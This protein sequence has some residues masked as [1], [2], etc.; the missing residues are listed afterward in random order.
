MTVDIELAGGIVETMTIEEFSR[1]MCLVEA[2][3]FISEKALQLKI[4]VE[5]LLKSNAID[6]Y[7]K[8]RYPAMLADLTTEVSLGLL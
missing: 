1:W 5:G 2:L 8:E 4:D 7:I 6:D 3:H